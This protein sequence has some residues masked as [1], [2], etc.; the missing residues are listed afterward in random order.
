MRRWAMTPLGPSSRTAYRAPAMG[1]YQC[2]GRVLAAEGTQ[3]C[4]V[5]AVDLGA[6]QLQALRH[7]LLPTGRPA[8]VLAVATLGDAPGDD[9]ATGAMIARAARQWGGRMVQACA[10]VAWL[11][12]DFAV[13][14]DGRCWRVAALG[15]LLLCEALPSRHADQPTRSVPEPQGSCEPITITR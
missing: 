9:Y 8:V 13:H 5:L 4:H 2:A 1:F 14:R 3:A 12:R 10:E 15:M 11:G 6:G 7:A